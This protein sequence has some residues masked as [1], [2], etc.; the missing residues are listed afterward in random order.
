MLQLGD[1][2]RILMAGIT[3]QEVVHGGTMQT[4]SLGDRTVLVGKEQG[5]EVDNLLTELSDSCRQSVVLCTE[6]LNLGLQIGKP[7][8]LALSALECGDPDRY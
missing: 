2:I 3:A 6:E 5:L 8:L 4:L 7:L 1:A